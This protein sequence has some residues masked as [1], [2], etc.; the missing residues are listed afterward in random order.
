MS[1]LEPGVLRLEVLPVHGTLGVGSTRGI[2]I[3]THLTSIV[4]TT[5]PLR[6]VKKKNTPSYILLV[7]TMSDFP[8]LRTPCCLGLAHAQ[9]SALPKI[10]RRL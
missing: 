3:A 9:H 6:K 5:E 7:L 1:A 4:S 8:F 2:K 10:F